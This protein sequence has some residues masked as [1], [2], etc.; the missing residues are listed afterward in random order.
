MD[1]EE[2]VETNRDTL[3]SD[4]IL[5][6]RKRYILHPRGVAWIGTPAGASPTDAEF[7]TG[8][9]WQKAYTDKNIRMVAVRH[10]V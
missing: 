1:P 10:N 4:D 8:T 9:N 5:V 2:A 7:A 3:G 6:N